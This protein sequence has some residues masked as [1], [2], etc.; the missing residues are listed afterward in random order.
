[1]LS[2]M[3][4][5]RSILTPACTRL[6]DD[7]SAKALSKKAVLEAGSELLAA[8]FPDIDR[9]ALL[10]GL[11]NRERLGSTALGEGVAIPHCRCEQC[12]VPAAALLRVRPIDFEAPDDKAVDLVFVLAVPFEGRASEQR[13]HLEIL[14]AL[15]RVFDHSANLAA[16]RAAATARALFDALQSQID[17]AQR[18]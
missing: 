8:R 1:M 14:G 13:I 18:E 6:C 15:S 3:I 7:A 12:P 2:P 17:A 10:E 16:L 9:R 5:F 11:L 4:D